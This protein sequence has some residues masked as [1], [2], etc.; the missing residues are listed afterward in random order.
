VEDHHKYCVK[1][2]NAL[3]HD[4]Q[5]DSHNFCG[6]N[7]IN[8]AN[9][10]EPRKTNGKASKNL[11]PLIA[12]SIPIL[13]ICICI[14]VLLLLERSN[15]SSNNVS[16]LSEN[17]DLRPEEKHSSKEEI[18]NSKEEHISEEK[19][20][21][22]NKENKKENRD[23]KVDKIVSL[24]AE[25]LGSDKSSIEKIL[26]DIDN[27]GTDELV[28]YG[29]N[30]S[31][32]SFS[33]RMAV[34]N[35]EQ[36]EKLY[37]EDRDGPYFEIRAIRNPKYG[38]CLAIADGAR[39]F[40]LEVYY[41]K[42][43]ELLNIAWFDGQNLWKASDENKDGFDE[44]TVMSLCDVTESLGDGPYLISTYSWVD[45]RYSSISHKIG[46]M[47]AQGNINAWPEYDSD[48]V[49]GIVENEL[50][51]QAIAIYDI[52]FRK[53]EEFLKWGA[54]EWLNAVEA[55]GYQN[56][57]DSFILDGKVDEFRKYMSRYVSDQL[58][59]KFVNPIKRELADPNSDIYYIVVESSD[60]SYHVLDKQVIK[61]TQKE[62]VCQVMLEV[63]ESFEGED[64]YYS[65]LVTL[66]CE[67]N[68]MQLI[69][70]EINEQSDF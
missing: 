69:L 42:D 16:V 44:I 6:N 62:F 10:A 25:E 17:A 22:Q 31:T 67:K 50:L 15:D 2:G 53:T 56:G 43:N 64:Y 3:M 38:N 61:N 52:Y 8:A 46:I 12:V 33:Y 20:D 37:S 1:C 59:N 14:T 7:A 65:T 63:M 47:D 66:T 19:N 30:N 36:E 34:F 70:T 13:A 29:F 5:I 28:L 18:H 48:M 26:V 40:A 57:V 49:A 4:I 21:I 55:S 32:N 68:A 35:I 27:K 24:F 11:K 54:Y 41:Y 9:V 58:I 23:Y 45:D 39:G 51:N 60:Y